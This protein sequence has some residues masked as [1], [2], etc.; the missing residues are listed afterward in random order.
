[1]LANADMVLT[2]G[3]RPLLA[4]PAAMPKRFCSA[5]PTLKTRCGNLS[6][7]TPILVLR[8]RSAVSATMRGSA[9]ARSQRTRP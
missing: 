6:W 5:M 1:M 9:S 8:A 3:S 2:N 7:K 4:M